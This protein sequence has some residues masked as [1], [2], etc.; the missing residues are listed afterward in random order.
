MRIALCQMEVVQGD[1]AGNKERA[2]AMIREAASAGAAVV[3]LPEMWTCGYDFSRLSEHTEEVDGPTGKQL[4][5]WARRYRVWLVGGSFPV[6]FE[7]GVSNTS[8]TYSPDGTLVNL[9]RKLHLIGLMQEDRYL[10]P[11][12]SCATFSLG[13]GRAGVMICYDLRFP[14]LART[15]ALEGA[16]VIFVPAQWP[17]QRADHWKAL[18]IARAIENQAYVVG[19]NMTG[20]NDRDRFAGGSLAVDPWGRVV[21]E[22][23]SEPAV[24]YADLDF[25]LVN[26]VR[27]RMP[28]FRDR[29]P[30][31]YRL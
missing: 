23:G 17:V 28:V 11:G 7:E 4:Q 3:V 19:V 20:H 6:S 25:A 12:N 27:S 10:T 2:E 24:L 15:Y 21:A 26:E 18:I 9:Y 30:R 16:S 13:S 8:L 5:E 22:G 1:R 14:E 29:R 31:A